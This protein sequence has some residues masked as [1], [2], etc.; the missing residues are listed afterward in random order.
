MNARTVPAA[1]EP[2][3]PLPRRHRRLLAVAAVAASVAL[4][5]LGVGATVETVAHQL[6]STQAAGQQSGH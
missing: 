3:F 2:R 5:A 1:Q 4:G 6:P